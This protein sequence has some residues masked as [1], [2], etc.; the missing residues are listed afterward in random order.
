MALKFNQ[1]KTEAPKREKTPSYKMKSG[2][3]RIRI[4]G[5]V[6]ARYIYWIPNKDG[7]KSPVECLAFNRETQE[8]DNAEKD[9]VKEYFPDAKPEWAFA[10]VCVD[11]L[12][13]DNVVRIFN[14]KRKLFGVIVDMAEDLGDPSDVKTG[15]DVVF[16]RDKTGPKVYNVEYTVKQLR[17]KPRELTEDESA[18]FEAAPSIDEI[19][20]R[21]TPEDIKKYLDDLRGTVG[22]DEDI[23]DEIPTDF[24]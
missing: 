15:W 21:P 16:S 1:V 17:C 19:L 7:V 8:F 20:R 12:D 18:A 11:T 5:G 22:A 3:N 23:D 6:L 13:N 10:S 2:E 24:G 14:H 4:Y 9:W